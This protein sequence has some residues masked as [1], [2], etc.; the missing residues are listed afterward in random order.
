MEGS[1]I[2]GGG[3]VSIFVYII[4]KY[5]DGGRS[6]GLSAHGFDILF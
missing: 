4:R 2:F 1:G 3:L 5:I 6:R